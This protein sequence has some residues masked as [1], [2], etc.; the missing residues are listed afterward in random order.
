MHVGVLL[1]QV[2]PHVLMPRVA[3]DVGEDGLGNVVT[4]ES[5][6]AHASTVVNKNHSNIIICGEL[7]AGVGR[8]QRR[9]K[10]PVLAGGHGLYL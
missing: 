4:S 1:A 8:R 5:S 9:C 6:F 2:Q 10:R 7:V 3:H